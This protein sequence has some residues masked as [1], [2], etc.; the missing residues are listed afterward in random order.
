MRN[1]PLSRRSPSPGTDFTK[2]VAGDW[3]D[4]VATAVETGEARKG[5]GGWRVTGGAWVGWRRWMRQSTGPAPQHTPAD[6]HLTRVSLTRPDSSTRFGQTTPHR[7]L[8]HQPAASC[9]AADLPGRNTRRVAQHACRCSGQATDGTPPS[10]S[11]SPARLS[12]TGSLRDA[13]PASLS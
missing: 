10:S 9:G 6:R 4:E 13:P 7:V 8:P 1:E 12:T 2:F 11:G 3:Y 5:M